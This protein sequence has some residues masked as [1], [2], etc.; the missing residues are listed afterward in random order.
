MNKIFNKIGLFLALTLVIL[1]SCDNEYEIPGTGTNH[2]YATTSF[3]DVENKLQ[4]NSVMSFIDL[5]RGVDGRTWTFTEDALDENGVNITAS[6][7]SVVKVQFTKAGVHGIVLKQTFA[8]NVWVGETQKQS[9][10]Y[11]SII[12]VTVLDSVKASFDA[13]QIK[14]ATALVNA[15]NALNEVFAGR[16]IQFTQTSAELMGADKFVWKFTKHGGATIEYDG[17]DLTAKFSSVG[18]YDAM[19]I[20]SNEFSRDTISY[21]SYLSI[22][23][24]TDPVELLGLT[25]DGA[26]KVRFGRDM[27]YPTTCDPTSFTVMVTNNGIAIPVSVTGLSLDATDNSIVILALSGELFNSDVVTISYDATVG[28]LITSDGMLSDSFTDE[29]VIFI[30]DNV[31]AASAYDYGFETSATEDWKY[32]WWGAPWDKYT[33]EVSTA[34]FYSGK[35]SGYVAMEPGGGMIMGLKTAPPAFVTFT[36]KA[37]TEYEISCWIYM[38]SI[39]D[40]ASTPDLRCYWSAKV[41]W[42]VE[43]AFFTPEF[44]EGKWVYTS[45]RVNSPGAGEYGFQLRGNNQGN[46][47]ACSFY[48]DEMSMSVVE[49]RK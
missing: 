35:N 13:V 29:K 17:A 24:S 39:G 2:V 41:D 27:G 46:S 48:F 44:E 8:D 32:L 22:V 5:S 7:E 49:P 23:A 16:E 10:A 33:F 18:V 12:N 19:L 36:T 38:E 21:D 1:W 42:S 3:G 26:L 45:W 43:G 9:N 40:R 25:V 15:D 30:T 34:Q 47:E 31:L 6:T 11:D 4:V 14:E 20:A 37:N 28:D